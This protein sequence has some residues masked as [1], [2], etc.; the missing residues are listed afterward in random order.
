MLSL[1]SSR[2]LI[3]REQNYFV[4]AARLEFDEWR[5]KSSR[6]FEVLFIE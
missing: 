6:L 1:K 5:L 2:L 3:S 4:L